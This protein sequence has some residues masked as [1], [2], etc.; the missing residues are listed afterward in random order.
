MSGEFI[1]TNSEL[2]CLKRC[3]RLHFYRYGLL[4]VPVRDAVALARGTAAHH[5]LEDVWTNEIPT[6][7][8]I[9]SDLR[10]VRIPEDPMIRA[11]CHG[12]LARY[13]QCKT[14]ESDTMKVIAVEKQMTFT[15]AEGI[16]VALKLDCLIE[17]NDKRYIVEHKTSGLDTSIGADYW[18]ALR[19]DT[20]ISTY[21][22]ACKVNGIDVDGVLYDVLRKPALKPLKATPVADRQY[23]IAKPERKNKK[24]GEITPAEPSRLYANQRENDETD[25]EYYQRCMAAIAE[26]PDRYFI[27]EKIHKTDAE[28]QDA[29]SELQ[30]WAHRAFQNV[31]LAEIIGSDTSRTKHLLPVKN[32]TGCLKW[33]RLCEY[34]PVCSGAAQIESIPVADKKHQELELEVD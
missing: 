33:G 29:A 20:Q 32:S 23:T 22:L 2:G 3:E 12:Y 31:A 1:A 28:L 27:R 9:P 18:Q 7:S 19:L 5:F 15:I 14:R 24:T 10:C 26:E 11:L 16:T 30:V 34:F 13:P 17:L 4:R 25:E 6:Q 8:I 21:M